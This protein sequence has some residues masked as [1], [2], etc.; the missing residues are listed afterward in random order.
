PV[1]GSVCASRVRQLVEKSR[2]DLILNYWLYPE[3][4][5]A[6]RLA[7]RL[8]V[9][10]VVCAIGS[11][12]RRIPEA[13]TRRFTMRT[14]REASAVLS[15]S[16]ELRERI[17]GMGIPAEKVHAVLNGCDFGVFHPVEKSAARAA[18]GVNPDAELIVFAGS[19]IPTKGLRELK[20]A[21][22]QLKSRRPRLQ[23]AMVGAGSLR[24]ELEGA[25]I[26]FPGLCDT[27]TV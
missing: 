21:F 22:L 2:P 26:L 11:D 9:P 7:R 23:L 12:I 14:L 10:S 17:I 1:N 15:V 27:A 8:G 13:V 20:Q 16:R 19:I 5:A 25:G 4:Y 6:V 24:P 18:V 3:G